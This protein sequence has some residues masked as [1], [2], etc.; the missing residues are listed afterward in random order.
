MQLSGRIKTILLKIKIL[1]RCLHI[2]AKEV[3]IINKAQ[4]TESRSTK[5]VLKKNS[6]RRRRDGLL[7]RAAQLLGNQWPQKQVLLRLLRVAGD[8]NVATLSGTQRRCTGRLAS[9]QSRASLLPTRIR[10]VR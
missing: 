6:P 9:P 2:E 5:Y 1:M 10:L 8:P 4:K 3:C 7:T